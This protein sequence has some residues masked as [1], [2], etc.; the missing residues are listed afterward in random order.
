MAIWLADRRPTGGGTILQLFM[1]GF[2][3]RK[4]NSTQTLA[5]LIRGLQHS[6]NVKISSSR[7]NTR[8]TDQVSSE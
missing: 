6:V 3:S 5:E 2:W 8:S 4:E 7:E 1:A